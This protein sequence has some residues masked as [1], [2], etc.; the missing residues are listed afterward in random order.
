MI[1]QETA[2]YVLKYFPRLLTLD[3]GMAIKHAMSLQKLSNSNHDHSTLT[4][5]YQ[6]KGWLSTDQNVLDLLKEGYEQ[7]EVDVAN[8]ILAQHPEKVFLNN[9]PQCGKLAR[10][11]QA[12]QCRFCG[13]NWHYIVLA[14]F[15]LHEVFQLMN[16]SS[17][18]LIGN[19][20]SGQ[21]AQ[22]DF[23]DLTS[24]GLNKK[25]KIELIEFV[26]KQQDGMSKEEIALGTNQLSE[27]E[28]QH[29]KNL[30]STEVLFD[31]IGKR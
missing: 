16:R 8:R 24:L 28:K 5:I 23:M 17:F 2:H 14:Q 22:G 19:I 18:F 3:E 7:F 12:K 25:P 15:K 1:D 11:P 13:F 31:I 10:T 26:V 30:K 6:E 29:L 21:F 9:C 27:D 4:K 20:I